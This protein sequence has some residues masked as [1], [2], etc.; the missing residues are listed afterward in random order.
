[1]TDPG[2][3]PQFIEEHYTVEPHV[4]LAALVVSRTITGYKFYKMERKG[5]QTIVTFKR[6]H[7][8]LSNDKQQP[9]SL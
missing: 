6:N 2:L 9:T 4:G 5:S 1:M 3:P 7:E 8:M